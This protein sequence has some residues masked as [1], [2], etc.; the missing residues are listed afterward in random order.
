MWLGHIKIELL[1]VFL[2][3]VGVLAVPQGLEIGLTGTESYVARWEELKQRFK[4]FCGDPGNRVCNHVPSAA[5]MGSPM[6]LRG[7][8]GSGTL[9]LGKFLEL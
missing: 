5:H 1:A 2:A 9:G 8:T 6:V 3:G 4:W 7:S